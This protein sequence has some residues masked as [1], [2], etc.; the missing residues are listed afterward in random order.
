ML[1]RSNPEPTDSENDATHTSGFHSRGVLPHLKRENASYFVT[2]RQFGTLPKNVLLKF[3]QERE[4]ILQNSVA[5]KRPLTWAEQKQL[6]QWY[7]ERVDNYLDAGHG[8]CLLKDPTVASLVAGAIQFF[9]GQRYHLH[10]WTIMPNHVH[11]VLK[12]IPPHTLSQILH[13]WKSFTAHR[14]PE[15][16][17]NFRP[18]FWQNESYDHLIRDDDDLHRCCHYTVINPVTARLCATP[19]AWPWSSA[20]RSRSAAAL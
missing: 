18:P 16:I 2:F 15:L 4:L 13:S 11:A 9:H 17:S 1:N 10:A 14:I 8:E 19:E 5:A 20:H 7:S 3:K 12:P 6:F